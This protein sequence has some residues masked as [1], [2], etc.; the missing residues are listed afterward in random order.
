[1]CSA[2]DPMQVLGSGSSVFSAIL[3]D[4]E[5]TKSTRQSVF[6]LLTGS[7]VLSIGYCAAVLA[8]RVF[9]LS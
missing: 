4:I 5:N 6:H 9:L 3:M 7:I 8:V 2:F 1:M